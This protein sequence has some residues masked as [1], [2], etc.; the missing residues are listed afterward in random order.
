MGDRLRKGGKVNRRQ[1][2]QSLGGAFVSLTIPI[3]AEASPSGS[4]EA[5]SLEERLGH[6]YQEIKE[7]K[8][9][10]QET[11]VLF[12]DGRGQKLYLINLQNGE[13]NILKTYRVSTSKYGFGN[14]F[15]SKKT[16]LGVHS[17]N[18]KY[19]RSAPLGT[20]FEIRMKTKKIANNL[21]DNPRS[22]M[23]T[24]VLSLEGLE[25]KNRYTLE[26]NIYIH[27]TTQE[28]S[29]GSPNSSGCIRMKNQEIN[30][31]FNLVKVDTYV[32]IKE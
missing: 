14:G 17:V 23:T 5:E 2:L 12:L 8:P 19:G 10:E 15:D 27:G 16:P 25:K 1:F 9:L 7:K 31:L 13:I 26:R 32:N 28:I 6:S 22:Y 29:V 30:E 20:I 3:L 4:L 11:P 24:R 21:N 18:E